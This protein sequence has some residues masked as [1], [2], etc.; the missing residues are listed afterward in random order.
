MKRL[1]IF[2]VLI[3]IVVTIVSIYFLSNIGVEEKR[4]PIDSEIRGIEN[5]YPSLKFEIDCSKLDNES[6]DDCQEF[7]YN[8]EH[9]LY[10]EMKRITGIDLRW[11]FDTIKYYIYPEEEMIKMFC[12]DGKLCLTGK[13]GG[14]SAYR[15]PEYSINSKCKMESHE[16]HHVLDNCVSIDTIREPL[17]WIGGIA[18]KNVCPD[19]ELP[20]KLKDSLVVEDCTSAQ[21]YI[22][23]NSNETFIHKFYESLLLIDKSLSMG[24]EEVEITEAII[25]ASNNEIDH[26]IKKYCLGWSETQGNISIVSA[27]CQNNTIKITIKNEGI[28]DMYI[29]LWYIDGALT[30]IYSLNCNGVG[31]VTVRCG[32]GL[33]PNGMVTCE[34]EGQGGEHNITIRGPKNQ[35]VET[36]TC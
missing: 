16:T 9:I 11:C 4:P 25:Y 14:N 1:I 5:P 31:C 23:Y 22:I 10:P 36:V 18:H 6:Q 35:A 34:F 19:Y 17:T 2:S 20:H 15:L 24:R 32:E 29:L 8:Q 27:F 28:E 12:P 33:N 7:I 13:A 3:A 26:N 21:A 30:P